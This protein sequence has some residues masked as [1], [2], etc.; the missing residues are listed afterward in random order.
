MLP[1]ARHDGGAIIPDADSLGDLLAADATILQQ[2]RVFA[3]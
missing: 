2:V 1:R 3:V